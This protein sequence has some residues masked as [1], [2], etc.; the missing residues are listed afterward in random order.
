[1]TRCCSLAIPATSYQLCAGLRLKAALVYMKDEDEMVFYK[2]MECAIN[3]SV[4]KKILVAVMLSPMWVHAANAALPANII[5]HSFEMR[6]VSGDLKADGV[7][8]FKGTT[9]IFSTD[10]RVAFLNTYTD[11]ASAWFNVPELDKLAVD[12]AEAKSALA[13]IKPQP[14]SSVRQQIRLN[15]GWQQAGSETTS[16]KN[17]RPWRTR[18]GVSVDKGVLNLS[19][20]KTELLDLSL[21]KGWRSEISW[22]AKLSRKQ[23]QAS[24]SLGCATGEIEDV[25]KT[26]GW[27]SYRLQLDFVEKCGYAS[28][29]GKRVNEFPL[30][31]PAGNPCPFALTATDDLCLDDLLF[32]DYRPLD[33]VRM[34]YEVVVLAD[35]SFDAK[36]DLQGWN[37]VS[38]CGTGWTSTELPAVRG[39]F[40]EAGSDLLLRRQVKLPAAK[41]VWLEVEALDPSGEIY[42]NGKLAA[43]VTNRKPVFVDVSSIAR[44]GRNLLAYRVN[45]H[46]VTNACLHAPAD[47]AIGWSAGRTTLHV[48]D[49]DVGLR[50]LRVHTAVLDSKGVADQMHRLVLDNAGKEAFT[51]TLEI[52]YRSWFPVEGAIVSMRRMPVKVGAQATCEVEMNI[53]VVSPELWSPE[54]PALYAVSARLLDDRDKPI[55]DIVTTTGIRTVAQREGMFLLNGAP[56]M[57]NG[58]QIMGFRPVPALEN[59]AKYNRRAPALSLMSELLAIKNMGGNLLRIHAHA[60]MTTPDGIHDPRIA[61]MADQLGVALMWGSP[62]WLREGDE[63][64]IGCDDMGAYIRDVYN[65][66]SI[67]IWEMSNHPNR[68]KQDPGP[69]RTHAFVKRTVNAVLAYDT[70][71]LI[72]PTTFWQHTSYANDLGT[73]DRK[74]R[75]ITPVAEYTHPLVT[76]G[77]QDAVTGDG[78]EWSK[79]RSWPSGFTADC[80]KN[81]IRAWFNFEHEESAAQANWNLS[82]GWP[83]HHLRSYEERYEKGSIGRVLDFNE[84]RASQGWQAFSAYESMRKQIYGGV[85]GFSWCT[86]EGGANSGTYEKPLLDPFGYAKLAWHIHKMVFQPVLAGSVDVDTVYGP[87]DKITPCVFNLGPARVVNLTLT[88]K[89]VAGV[90]LDKKT[91][92]ALKLAAGRSLLRLP[93]V[94]PVLPVK[95][96]CV[97]EYTVTAH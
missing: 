63:R 81:N 62:A 50:D 5:S 43:T 55:D 31:A 67:V 4:T 79:L 11:I 60:A 16:I 13:S 27:H 40:R 29:D 46:T 64:L 94:R 68:F 22:K 96:L 78:A 89:S 93:P 83:W 42:L 48:L 34:P 25:G 28:V 10:E 20:G 80:L 15:T 21:S 86:I 39:G 53:G 97:I 82:K 38:R 73:L 51:G 95:G 47:I 1:V 76:R 56:A 88:V 77:T 7:T 92:K 69:E 6:G 36:P 41:R 26:D 37:K 8:D 85:D 17:P 84:W 23:S 91:F 30:T 2:K 24:W 44:S 65:H 61:E 90:I 59:T 18:S 52:S 12:P 35:D 45:H 9:S 72:S 57:L 32:L 87:N 58:A 74:G 33:T 71:R 49:T 3:H 66:P 14:L 54:R 70:S 19:S 75:P